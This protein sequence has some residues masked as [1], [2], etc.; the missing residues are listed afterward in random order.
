ME[1]SQRFCFSRLITVQ[2]LDSFY[3]FSKHKTNLRDFLVFYFPCC[4]FIFGLNHNESFSFSKPFMHQFAHF[5]P[6]IFIRS[7]RTVKILT[8]ILWKDF[9]FFYHHTTFIFHAQL[10]R[11]RYIHINHKMWDFLTG[12]LYEWFFIKHYSWYMKH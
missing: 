12:T 1:K 6:Q 5:I 9:L 2:F 8:E 11:D 3:N 10:S 4:G 7:D